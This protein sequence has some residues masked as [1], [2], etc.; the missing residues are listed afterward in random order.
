MEHRKIITDGNYQNVTTTV[1]LKGKDVKVH[2]L[3]VGTVFL[4]DTNLSMPVK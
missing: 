4:R 2:A 3:C 1:K